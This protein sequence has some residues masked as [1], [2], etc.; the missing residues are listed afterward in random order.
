MTLS[1]GHCVVQLRIEHNR[2]GRRKEGIRNVLIHVPVRLVFLTSMQTIIWPKEGSTL[3]RH[4]IN[5]N[6]LHPKCSIECQAYSYME[7][8]PKVSPNYTITFPL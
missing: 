3:P 5:N 2:H 4:V 6:A 1:F 7:K 8:I